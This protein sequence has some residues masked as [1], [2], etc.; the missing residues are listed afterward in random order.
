MLEPSA[1]GTNSIQNATVDSTD[2][3]RITVASSSDSI[4]FTDLN[5]TVSI[6]DLLNDINFEATANFDVSHFE[7]IT[8]DLYQAFTHPSTDENFEPF[9]TFEKK[10]ETTK[11][12][13]S[14]QR[15]LSEQ[16]VTSTTTSPKVIT[17]TTISTLPMTENENVKE[18]EI[19]QEPP[20]DDD[21]DNDSSEENVVLATY[22]PDTKI[23]LVQNSSDAL[24]DHEGL[25][26]QEIP[27]PPMSPITRL[28]SPENKIDLDE[29]LNSMDVECNYG[30]HCLN[31][32]DNDYDFYDS[33][34]FNSLLGS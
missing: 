17:S 25:V 32:M 19:K 13:K 26:K 21:D 3:S 6:S 4:N 10:N 20:D 29:Q 11:L 14:G 9:N 7:S 23:I 18:P 2:T 33:H 12:E 5:D 31:E 27:T 34:Y 1:E 8:N 24:I 15:S 22:D 30:Y 16:I 28:L